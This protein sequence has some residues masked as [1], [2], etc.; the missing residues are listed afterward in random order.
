MAISTPAQKP[1]GSARRTRSTAIVR[2]RLPTAA[3]PP[4]T[5]AS[6]RPCS[7]RQSLG[8][9]PSRPDRRPTQAGLRAGDTIALVNGRVPRDVIEWRLWTDEPAVELDVSRSGLELQLDV[10]KP[11]GQPL[12]AEV[13]SAVFDR[14]RT[15]D[16]HCEFCFIYQ[17]PKGLRRSLYLKDDDY[18]L[19]FLYGNFTTLTR[20]TEADLERVITERLSP[21]H[22]S[23]HSTDPELRARMLRNPRGA[24]SLRWLRALLDHGIEVRGQLVVCPGVNDGACA[25]RHVRRHPRSLPGAVVGRRRATRRL[26]VQPGGRDARPHHGRGRGGRRRGGGLA[27]RVP[28]G[29]RPADGPRR[30]RVLPDGRPAVPARRVPTRASRC[31]RTASAW[32][33]R[34]SSSSPG[35]RLSR[36]ARDAGF[37]AAVDGSAG[38]LPP[39]PAA[40]TGLRAATLDVAGRAAAPTCRAGRD[41]LRRARCPG[42]ASAGRRGSTTDVRVIPVANEFFGGNTGV[43]GLMTG[44]DLT[45]VLA[46]EPE[47]HRY[48]LPD[49]CLSDDGRFLDGGT[50]DDLPRPVE[51]VA[52][53]G[54]ALREALCMNGELPVVAVVGR[55]NVGKST[56]F[57]RIVGEQAAIVEDR[58][59]ITRDRKELEAEWLGVPFRIIDTGGW[60]PG[61]SD[62]EVKVSRQVEAAV[63]SCR[64]RAVRRRWLG[65]RDGRGRGDRRLVAPRSTTTW[66]SSPTRPT[67][68]GARTSGG[69]SWR[70][71]SASRTRSARCTAGGPAICSTSSSSGSP[72]A[73]TRSRTRAIVGD[74][75]EPWTPDEPRPPRVAIVG[76]PNVGK[77]TL[78]NRLVGE[79]RSV[80]HD[81]AGTTRDAIDTLV[82]TE[83]GP[84]VFVD[85]AGMR[86]RSRIDDSAEY[87]SLVRALRAIDDADIA[88]LVIDATEGVTGQDQRLAERIDAAGCP[89]VILL[90]KWELIADPDDRQIVLAE[91]A[92]RLAFIGEAPVLRISAL[93]GKGVHRLRPVL[94]EAITQYHRRVPTRDVNRV[95][96]EAQQRQ[97]AGGGAKVLYAVQGA[98]DPPTFT[99]FANRE[100][101]QTYVRYLERSIR[102]AFGFGSTPLKLRV[103]RRTG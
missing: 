61:G 43:T 81:L 18:R 45:R 91:L 90:N 96:V 50:V 30:R 78:F 58:P 37:F 19:S 86:R 8:R 69:S 39:N 59:G 26:Q 85:T 56:L 34:S 88:L 95:L 49:V 99:L 87:Y 66:S 3:V 72:T 68:T 97:P 17:L 79:D 6:T 89:I 25:R 13:S 35:R 1:R 57:N 84:I 94:Q 71:G 93:S 23:I 32:P 101:P 22:V 53:D 24:T 103:R 15:C 55:P 102:E 76:R 41:P 98:S 44:A 65:R 62:L 5:P 77:S 40:Y 31:T 51:V 27:G 12:G 54:H 52:T 80:V 10:H 82:E 74:G 70:S 16:N 29:A 63:R 11:A 47:G 20:F 48:L 9:L 64:R 73:T 83:D 28:L 33:A 7:L 46:A 14:V 36:P 92:R 21:L 38:C 4:S 60:S 2:P 100:L 75:D 67:T 42:R